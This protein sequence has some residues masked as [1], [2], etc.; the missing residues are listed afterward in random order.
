MQSFRFRDGPT[1]QWKDWESHFSRSLAAQEKREIQERRRGE[2]GSVSSRHNHNNQ[3]QHHVYR[4][5][6]RDIMQY[7]GETQK[8]EQEATIDRKR[9]QERRIIGR[10]LSKQERRNVKRL[11]AQG[12]DDEAEALLITIRSRQHISP[13][14]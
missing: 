1:G 3:G 13:R 7:G 10:P 2:E 11:R 4:E 5:T 8:A 6:F 12:R 14:G 9:S